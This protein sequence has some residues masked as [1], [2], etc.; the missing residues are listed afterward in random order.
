MLFQIR[1]ISEFNGQLTFTLG[2]ELQYSNG[3][4]QYINFVNKPPFS[5]FKELDY[6]TIDTEKVAKYS[7]NTHSFGDPSIVGK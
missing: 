1:K 6:I 2:S 7:T 3:S 4:S 5:D